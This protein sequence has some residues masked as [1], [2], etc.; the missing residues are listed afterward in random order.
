MR[1]K[2]CWTPSPP[3]SLVLSMPEPLPLRAILST[4]SMYTIPV[5][6]KCKHLDHRTKRMWNLYLA[7]IGSQLEA[8]SY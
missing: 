2:A 6:E 1:S 3:T 8:C 7:R 4:S 5:L